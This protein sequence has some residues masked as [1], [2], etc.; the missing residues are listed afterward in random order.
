VTAPSSIPITDAALLDAFRSFRTAV[1]VLSAALESWADSRQL[2]GTA[3]PSPAAIS[4][5][6]AATGV[7]SPR[8]NAQTAITEPS[9]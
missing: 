1:D 2:P 3:G 9:R 8:A 5:D 7:P 6:P 4:P